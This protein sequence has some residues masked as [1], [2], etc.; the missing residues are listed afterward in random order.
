MKLFLLSI[1]LCASTFCFGQTRFDHEK[2]VANITNY[3]SEEINFKVLHKKDSIQLSGTLLSPKTP[4]EIVI[5]IVP[6]SGADTRNSHY[7]LTEKLLENNISV[8]RYDERGI[9]KSEGKFNSANY[10]ITA[11][12]EELSSCI[13]ALKKNKFLSGKKIG[14][15]GHSQGGLVTMQT[16]EKGLPIDFMVQWATP[17]QKHGEFIKYQIKSGQNPQDDVLKFESIDKKI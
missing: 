15:L 12:S 5:I 4:S 1:S 10:T 11:M 17:V 8:Y 3:N 14:L 13:L 2:E 7:L 9:G 6:G 16:F